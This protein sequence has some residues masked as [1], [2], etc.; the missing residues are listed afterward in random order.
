MNKYIPLI[1]TILTIF[2]NYYIP[3][4]NNTNVGYVSKKLE[5]QP[6]GWTFSIWG[7]I[8]TALIYLTYKITTNEISWSNNSILLY[9]LTCVFNVTWI[10]YWTKKRAD[11]SQYLLVGIVL[12]LFLIWNN[13]IGFSDK[14][15]YQNIIAVY[16]S[17]TLGASLINIFI[18]NG[19]NN[20]S[21]SKTI[22]YL[23]SALQIIWQI[24]NKNNITRLNDSLLFPVTATWTGL[25]IAL[26]S[27][28]NLGFLKYVP[29]IISAGSSINHY[30]NMGTPNLTNLFF[31]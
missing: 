30:N 18:V 8:Y 6:A 31:E 5:A 17:W 21:S 4:L 16:L 3:L 22:I 20:I 28:K 11:I 12:L 9:F 2:G 24:V 19:S 14:V 10:Y 29:L 13:N 7:F 23:I 15:I 26:N 25:G 27:S 1:S